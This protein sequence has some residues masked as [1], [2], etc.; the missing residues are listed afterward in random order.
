MKTKNYKNNSSKTG[1]YSIKNLINNKQYTGSTKSSFHSRKTKHY[2]NLIKNT[3]HNEYLQNAWN[4]YGEENFIFELIFICPIDYVV[5]KEAFFI[6]NLKTNYREHGYNIASVSEYRFNYKLSDK[7]NSEKSIKKLKKNLTHN[8]LISNE[9]GLPK[10]FKEYNLNGDFI[11]EY[12]SAKEYC[13][14]NGLVSRAHISVCLSKR[15]LYYRKS[16]VLFSND[17]LTKKDIEYVNK[18]HKKIGVNL[19]DIHHTFIESFD[20]VKECAI[21]VGCKEAEVRMCSLG[22]RS[23]IKNFVTKYK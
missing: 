10:P 2:T 11:A 8:G 19:Y 5:K 20:T 23:R 13:E 22:Y 7:H 12:N 18:K 9:R 3:H 1:I 6:K 14:I 16:I 21:F 4:K 17:S 15:N